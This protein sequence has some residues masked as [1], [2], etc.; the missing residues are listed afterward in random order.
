MR[1]RGRLIHQQFF[2]SLSNTINSFLYHLRKR[3]QIPPPAIQPFPSTSLTNLQTEDVP[4]NLIESDEILGPVEAPFSSPTFLAN[5]S[6]AFLNTY[7]YPNI[8]KLSHLYPNLP[9]KHPLPF[10]AKFIGLFQYIFLNNF[11]NLL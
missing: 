9:F 2:S 1:R 4:S 5:F 8:L 3:L 6:S 7:P 10:D 11:S